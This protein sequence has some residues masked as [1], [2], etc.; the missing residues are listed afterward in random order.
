MVKKTYLG[1]ST[2]IGPGSTWFG[3]SDED[4]KNWSAE[5]IEDSWFREV[6]KV[7]SLDL[8]ER[9]QLLAESKAKRMRIKLNRTKSNL[10]R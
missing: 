1:G 9:E 7:E 4:P 8:P 2:I 10:D 3:K 5:T 6:K